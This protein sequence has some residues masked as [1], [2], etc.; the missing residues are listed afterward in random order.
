MKSK[1]TYQE[2]SNETGRYLSELNLAKVNYINLQNGMKDQLGTI[3]KGSIMFIGRIIMS[4]YIKLIDRE[5][6]PLYSNQEEESE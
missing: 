6:E 2:I 3:M 1:K 4:L 5:M